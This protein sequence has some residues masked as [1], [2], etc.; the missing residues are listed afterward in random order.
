[1]MEEAMLWW[2]KQCHGEGSSA[3]ITEAVLWW[4]KLC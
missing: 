1:M 2:S 3:M 4:R